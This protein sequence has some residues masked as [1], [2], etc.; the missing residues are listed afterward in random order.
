MNE[1]SLPQV[2]LARQPILDEQLKLFAYELLFRRSDENA[3]N[4]LD[5]DT[6]TSEVVLN[7]VTGITPETLRTAVPAFINMTESML[8]SGKAP[9]VPPGWVV[10]EVLETVEPTARVIEG[11]T[12]LKLL[13]YRLALDD[14]V[15]SER[16]VPM[17]RLVDFIK[18]DIR[19]H[20]SQQ[21]A[22]QVQALRPF[23]VRL[24]AEKIETHEEL[25]NCR[26]LGFSLFQGYF[27]HRPE[28][29]R[30][31]KISANLQLVMTILT[32]LQQE[33][34]SAQM[35][36]DL[37]NQDAKL[38]YQLLR[39]INS[40]AFARPRAV[41]SVR[42]AVVL[43]G[44]RMLRN[45][46]SLIAM[47]NAH[48]KPPELMTTLLVRARMAENLAKALKMNSDSAFTSGLFSGLDALFDLPMAQLLQQL[49]LN[50]EVKL[51]LAEHGGELGRLIRIILHYERGEFG[52]LVAL[53]VALTDCQQAYMEALVWARETQNNLSG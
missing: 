21:L 24:L 47:A 53:N 1:S 27:L 50:A 43:L 16:H 41:N 18:I 40:A 51:A 49:P 26:A 42:E 14:F 28:L 2:L 17:I 25:E 15:F 34:S 10:L 44:I 8:V 35:I 6:A 9:P 52:E 23:N 38:S 4:V 36:A 7:A 31:K 12:A 19:A 37:V 29:V 45:W 3:A 48:T 13:G 32:A 30:G 33:K 20:D 22:E 5:G 11:L 46:I 39:I